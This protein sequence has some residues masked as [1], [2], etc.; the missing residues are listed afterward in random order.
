[1]KTN[2]ISFGSN[3]KFLRNQVGLHCAYCGK[4]ILQNRDIEAI[5]RTLE[6]KK[7]CDVGKILENYMELV[8]GDAKAFLNTIIEYS[9]NSK[10]KDWTFKQLTMLGREANIY[11]ANSKITLENLLKSAMFSVEHA[12]PRSQEGLNRY[13]NYLPMHIGCNRSRSS[14]SYSVLI[15]ENPSLVENL[16]KSLLE[17]KERV[18]SDKSGKSH[19]KISL[20]EDYFKGI[21]DSIASQGLNRKVFED[22]L[23]GIS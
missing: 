8:N 21:I 5:H 4:L 17:I 16:R 15:N 22:I 19:F 6:G 10:F 9:K 2:S 7:G 23:N 1:M 20:P 18:L 12:I 3:Y 14:D 13:T 11:N